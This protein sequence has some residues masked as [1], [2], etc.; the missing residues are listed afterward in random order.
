MGCNSINPT[1]KVGGFTYPASPPCNVKYQNYSHLKKMITVRRES[2]FSQFTLIEMNLRE[3]LLPSTLTTHVSIPRLTK[4]RSIQV[5]AKEGRNV[6]GSLF[7]EESGRVVQRRVRPMYGQA[8]VWCTHLH[9]TS[10]TG[11]S[12]VRD[13]SEEFIITIRVSIKSKHPNN[14]MISL[15]P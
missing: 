9:I 13:E 2:H 5:Q 3:S 14:I 6:Y 7:Q 11:D 8:I 4:V 15:D 10:P 12:I 1:G